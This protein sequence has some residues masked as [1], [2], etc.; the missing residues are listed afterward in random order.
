MNFFDKRII[1]HFDFLLI[2]FILPLVLLSYFLISDT[3]EILAYKQLI[4][5]SLSIVTFVVIFFLPIRKYIRWVVVLYWVGIV[6]LLMVE[7][8]GITKLG[9]TR[10][11]SLP[12]LH[13][14]I[15]PSELIKPVFILMLGFIIHNNPPPPEVVLPL[16]SEMTNEGYS[17]DG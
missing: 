4:Y 6:L 2:L 3:N 14:T 9:A 12:F 5:F 17:W 13:M 16:A 1:S 7:F 8:V 10:W 11:L 15:Q